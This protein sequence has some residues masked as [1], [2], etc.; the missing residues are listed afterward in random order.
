[1][2]DVASLEVAEDWSFSEVRKAESMYASH[3][4]HRYPAKFIPQIVQKLLAK[5]SHEGDTILDPFGGCGTTLVEA[6]INGRQGISVDVNKVAV[7][8]TKAKMYSISP[9]VLA[10]K[11]DLLYKRIDRYKDKTNYYKNAHPKLKYWFKWS[12]YNKLKAIYNCILQE[13]NNKV[14]TFYLCC[15]SNILKNCS[16]WYSKSVKPMRDP[17]KKPDKPLDAFKKHLTYMTN[18]NENFV[19][20]LEEK[21]TLANVCKVLKGDARNLRM[22]DDSVDMIITSPPYV[23]SYEYADL[24]QLSTLWFEYTDDLSK[25]KK[26]FVGTSSRVRSKKIIS[27]EVAKDTIAKL[28]AKRKSLAK[29]ISNYYVDIEKCYREMYRVLK[30]NK[31]LSLILGDTEYL[32]VDIPN[33]KVSIELLESAGFRIQNV[34]KRRLSSKIFTP[35]RD[36]SGRFTDAEHSNKR[37][38]YQYEYII[39][40]KKQETACPMIS[41]LRR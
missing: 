14:R 12:Q 22:Q 18:M 8:I 11:N 16:I 3:G 6:K 2:I 15:F 41:S 32:G 38:I 5:Y 23:T 25:I 39:V 24:H 7:L 29:C 19:R 10:K 27:S 34:I 17:D 37:N 9:K 21:G 26:S 35:F 30:P 40:A 20:I 28:V 31:Q 13:R 33:T 4:Y 1:M 36:S